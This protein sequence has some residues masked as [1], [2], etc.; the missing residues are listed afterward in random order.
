MGLPETK[1]C[2]FAVYPAF[3][4]KKGFITPVINDGAVCV[5]YHVTDIEE[6]VIIIT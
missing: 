6:W 4:M 2:I 5:T 1:S 3:G